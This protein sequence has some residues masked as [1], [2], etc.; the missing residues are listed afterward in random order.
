MDRGDVEDLTESTEGWVAALQLAALSLRGSDDPG[1]LV[2]HLTDRHH[3][4]SE[5]LAENVLDTLEPGT[6]GFVVAT[7][8]TERTCGELATALTG[9]ADG[10]ALLEQIEQQDLVRRASVRERGGGSRTAGR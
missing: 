1:A 3:A 4:I 6:L 5:F 9:V 7:S 8:I 10:Q 2:G